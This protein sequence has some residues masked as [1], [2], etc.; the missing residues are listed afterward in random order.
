MSLRQEVGQLFMV[1]TPATSASRA[2]TAQIT[3]RHVGNVILTG[4]SDGGTSVP[5][6][7]TRALRAR[8]TARAT[9]GVDLLVAT[10]QEGG[11]VQVLNGRGF[12]DMPSGLRQG[13]WTVQHLGRR[14][15]VWAGQ[16][17]RAG[18]DMDLAPVEDTVPGPV[19]GPHNPPIGAYDRELGYR[20]VVVAR[21][22]RALVSGLSRH[23][24]I[25]ALKHFPGLGRVHA[26]PDTAGGVTDVVTRRRDPFLRPFQA[27]VDAGAPVVMV[28]TAYYRHLD[29]RRPAAFSSFVIR[30]VL[31]GDLGFRGVVVSDDLGTARQ[32][33]R[34]RPGVRA[35]RFVA[36]GGDLVLTVTPTTL[37]AMYGAVLSRAAHDQRFRAEVDR[38][39]LRVL[40]L[41]EDHGL[42]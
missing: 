9:Q 31:R 11:L 17:R 15:G 37:P 41:K 5:A 30:R 42:L 25:P 38:A 8:A 19:A 1:G 4:R 29:P 6:R 7:V 22:G 26:N 27:S 16:L 10:D 32:V 18:V 34:W 33:A 23:G 21:H 13:R 3:R 24:V 2:T 20:P 39:A 28:S 14:A 12:S 40:R 36:A 35:V